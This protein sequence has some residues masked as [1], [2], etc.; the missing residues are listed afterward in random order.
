MAGNQLEMFTTLNPLLGQF[1]NELSAYLKLDISNSHIPDDSY[2]IW[3]KPTCQTKVA[4]STSSS[5]I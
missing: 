4:A 5:W 3:V 1:L 2:S